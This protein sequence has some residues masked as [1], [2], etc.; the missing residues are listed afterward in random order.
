MQFYY[1]KVREVRLAGSGQ[2]SMTSSPQ[3]HVWLPPTEFLCSREKMFI[4]I[5]F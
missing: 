3:L 4:G 5:T 2:G 1:N